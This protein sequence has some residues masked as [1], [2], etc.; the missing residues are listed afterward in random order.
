MSP[1]RDRGDQKVRCSVK[2]YLSQ[3]IL[4][5][6][7]K[8][9]LM[10]SFMIDTGAAIADAATLNQMLQQSRNACQQAVKETQALRTTL[11]T[12]EHTVTALQQE[13]QQLR[14]QVAEA[15]QAEQRLAEDGNKLRED[16]QRLQHNINRI[17]A[18]HAERVVLNETQRHAELAQLRR[19]IEQLEVQL[20]LTQESSFVQRPLTWFRMSRVESHPVHTVRDV[21]LSDAKREEALRERGSIPNPGSDVAAVRALELDALLEEP[22]LEEQQNSQDD[23]VWRLVCK[24]LHKVLSDRRNLLHLNVDGPVDFLLRTRSVLVSQWCQLHLDILRCSKVMLALLGQLDASLRNTGQVNVMDLE[25]QLEVACSILSDVD[26][27]CHRAKIQCFSDVDKMIHG[28][29]TTQGPQGSGAGSSVAMDGGAAGRGTS[30]TG[31]S[32]TPTR[33][34]TPSRHP[35]RSPIVSPGSVR[36]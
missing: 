4:W 31:T 25:R 1:A 2:T 24:R 8:V 3:L 32:S 14:L 23:S 17:L 19:K 5:V 21:V 7:N 34:T 35:A 28:V 20:S 22:A 36:R 6:F 12:M 27:S 30:R 9:L 26:V 15:R 13:K 29:N 33:R 10:T 16:I 11:R 18:E